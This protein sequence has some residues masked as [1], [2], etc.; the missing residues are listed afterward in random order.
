MF[1]AL[2]APPAMLAA[3]K[4]RLIANAK[5]TALQLR[6][7]ELDYFVERYSNLATQASI[8]AGFAFDGLVE[9][10]V[11]NDVPKDLRW[12]E[13]VFYTAGSCTMAFSLY[14]LC[15]ASFATVYG[16]RLALQG[17]TG[18]VE[19]AVAVMMKSRTSIFVSF[20]L[21]LICLMVAGSAMA[22][23][24]MGKAAAG[25]TAIF[26]LLFVFLVWKHQHMKYAFRIDPETMVRGDVRLQVGATDIDVAT[27]EA[28]SAS[29]YVDANPLPAGSGSG[30]VQCSSYSSSAP[31]L[32]WGF[33]SGR[34]LD[35]GAGI[36]GTSS[37]S[38]LGP[39]P[40]MRTPLM[41]SSDTSTR[42]S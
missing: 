17:P 16:H 30:L 23:V 8:L 2:A 25:V 24:K 13:S 35:G 5:Q 21:A 11:G 42:A 14:T 34:T 9:L 19:R 4:D 28:G 32:G 10:D 7:K 1:P 36:G 27:L 12:L 37:S 41:Q 18:S 29:G 26:C 31:G 38:P 40:A 20:A 3:D 22:W 33:S 6:H 39:P 15:V